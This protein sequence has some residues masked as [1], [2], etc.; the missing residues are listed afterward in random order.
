MSWYL[1]AIR[2]Y[3]TFNGRARRKEYWFF[4]LFCCLITLGMLLVGFAMSAGYPPAV[5]RGVRGGTMALYI[6]FDLAM[7]LPG[8]AVS[9][10]RL[11]D[12]GRN[13]LWLLISMVPLVGGIVLLVFFLLDSDP[14]TNSFGPN[15][16]FAD[17]SGMMPGAR[18]T[19]SYSS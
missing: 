10:R 18:T 14:G 11:H 4:E 2:Q 15:P 9:V 3:A 1:Q 6:L 7:L 19:A 17:G 13:G 5:A 16:K 12:T 8:L